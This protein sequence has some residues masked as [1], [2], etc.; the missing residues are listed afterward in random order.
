MNE[1]V[2]SKLGPPGIALMVFGTVCMLFSLL[3]TVV[4]LISAMAQ[5]A[6]VVDSGFDTAILIN[7]M[8]SSGFGILSTCLAFLWAFVIIF[9]GMK[10]KSGQSP[11]LVYVACFLAG[12]PCCTSWCCCFGLP[13]S[14]WAIVTMQDEQVKAAFAEA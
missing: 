1:Y 6:I 12:F 4:Q 2:E 5:F 10:L 14:I 8:T 11:A 13:L 7:F 9:G 3:S